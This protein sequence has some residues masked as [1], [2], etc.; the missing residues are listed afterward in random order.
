VMT[1]LSFS[2]TKTIVSTE[3]RGNELVFVLIRH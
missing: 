3:A 2:T 1:P